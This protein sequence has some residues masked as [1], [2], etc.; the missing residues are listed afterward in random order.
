MLIGHIAFTGDSLATIVDQVLENTP[1]APG[2]IRPGTPGELNRLILEMISKQN[3]RRPSAQIVLDTLKKL[4]L[5]YPPG[6]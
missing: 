5:S 3:T 6:S 4:S 1:P 2:K